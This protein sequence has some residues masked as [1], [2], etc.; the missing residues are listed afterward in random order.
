MFLF[1]YSTMIC[2]GWYDSDSSSYDSTSYESSSSDHYGIRRKV[3]YDCS[4]CVYDIEDVLSSCDDCSPYN[5]VETLETLEDVFEDL[6]EDFDTLENKTEDIGCFNMYDEKED[7][8]SK[9]EGYTH[10]CNNYIGFIQNLITFA[11]DLQISLERKDTHNHSQRI[12]KNI[13]DLENLKS[14]DKKHERIY[15]DI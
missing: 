10:E 12:E 4:T 6:H 1:V 15:R 3:N 5:T 13:K 9:L 8:L 11:N 2:T 7:D 14:L